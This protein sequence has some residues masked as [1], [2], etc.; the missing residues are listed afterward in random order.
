MYRNLFIRRRELNELA[1]GA[2]VRL[3]N[4]SVK[5]DDD[6]ILDNLSLDINEKEFV[7]LLLI[8]YRPLHVFL[9]LHVR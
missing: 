7:T 1:H 8:R 4:I 6:Q 2:L 9:S 5:F 3:Q